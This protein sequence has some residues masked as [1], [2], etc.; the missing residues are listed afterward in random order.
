MGITF[1]IQQGGLGRRLPGLDYVTGFVFA[2]ADADLPSGFTTT[3]RIKKVQSLEQ[4][5]ALGITATA[6]PATVKALHYHIQ[7][8]FFQFERKTQSIGELWI[9]LYAAAGSYA[10]NNVT[11]L[12]VAASGRI[13]QFY[14]WTNVTFAASLVTVSAAAA[15][16]MLANNEPAII[17]VGADFSAITDLST[18]TNLRALAKEFV[19]VDIAQDGT[20][21]ADTLATAL[22]KSLGAGGTV[23]GIIAAANVS[24][25]IGW[26]QEFNLADGVRWEV[27]KLANGDDIK[28]VSS[29]NIALL[30]SSGYIFVRTRQGTSGA[31]FNDSPQTV[32]LTSDFAYIEN[33]R[34]IQ[35]AIREINTQLVPFINAPIQVNATTGKITESTIFELESA[36]F[37]ALN[38]MGANFE[39]SVDPATGRLPNNAVFI[40]PDQNVLATS[41]VNIVVRIVPI[42][43]QRQT[44]IN[45]GFTPQINAA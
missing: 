18:L 39:I 9:N 4:A 1:N 5:E 2:I 30:D 20:T 43:V 25:N 6:T 33:S 27:I 41:L 26:V 36:V 35:K 42:G 38:Q 3:D 19:S 32:P 15:A 31:F 44:V 21:E 23:L 28:D 34:T 29:A 7:E 12:Q 16:T 13:R 10:A 40:D 17:V 22:T 8:F 24:L 45:I 37:K 14:V 11:D